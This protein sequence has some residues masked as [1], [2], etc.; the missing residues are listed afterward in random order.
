MRPN[1]ATGVPGRDGPFSGT[2]RHHARE[3]R[4]WRS[5]ARLGAT[6]DECDERTPGRWPAEPDS[7]TEAPMGG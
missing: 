6:R 1:A 5:W 2:L 3:R 7:G 4:P